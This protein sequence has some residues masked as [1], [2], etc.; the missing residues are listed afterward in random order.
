M[1]TTLTK[2]YPVI[3]VLDANLYFAMVVDMV[4]YMNIRLPFCNELP[5]ALIVGIRYP[6]SG[7][8]MDQL[9]QVMHLRNAS[10]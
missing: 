7:S 1:R 4:R 10:F 2:P 5:D 8:P 6:V 3:Y 9:H